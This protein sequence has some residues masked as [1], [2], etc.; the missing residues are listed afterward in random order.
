MECWNI[1][2]LEYWFAKGCH[3]FL[4]FIDKVHF[5]IKP[6]SHY[7]TPIIPS[8][9]HSTFPFGMYFYGLEAHWEEIPSSNI[10]THR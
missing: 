5:L 6:S 3:W 7:P 8:F 9:H 10:Q 1:G 2:I 4:N